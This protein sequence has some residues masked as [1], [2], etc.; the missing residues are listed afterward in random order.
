MGNCERTAQ[1][2][3]SGPFRNTNADRQTEG[4]RLTGGFFSLS[5]LWT[6]LRSGN[7]N[8][9]AS[10]SLSRHFFTATSECSFTCWWGFECFGIHTWRVWRS[11]AV[12]VSLSC[13][14]AHL[15]HTPRTIYGGRG[16][17]QEQAECEYQR[18]WI[19]GWRQVSA[20]H[21]RQLV[22]SEHVLHCRPCQW[23]LCYIAQ[24]YGTKRDCCVHMW[25][26]R[27]F[28][29]LSV[30]KLRFRYAADLIHVS[31]H[32]KSPLLPAVKTSERIPNFLDAAEGR[33]RRNQ[34][35]VI[36]RRV[37]FILKKSL[38]KK[39]A[40]TGK[41][42]I[43]H[44]I[45]RGAFILTELFRWE[46]KKIKNGGEQTGE[47]NSLGRLGFAGWTLPQGLLPFPIPLIFHRC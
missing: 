39:W 30:H 21:R 32:L 5:Q 37:H 47:R 17:S 18:E 19:T 35:G 12:L 20:I 22:V 36:N 26:Q 45:R 8:N 3:T 9:G 46:K 28:V 16:S 38:K 4:Q 24:T 43:F 33:S 31:L 27:P 40:A 44:C 15:A 13:C 2:L 10:Q 23:F 25:S 14:L 6:I 42:L 41:N 34:G 29:G 7:S 11:D 1:V